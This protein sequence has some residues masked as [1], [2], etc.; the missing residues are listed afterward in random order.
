MARRSVTLSVS[1]GQ[2]FGD[3][4]SAQKVTPRRVGSAHALCVRQLVYNR[5]A[6]GYSSVRK[7]DDYCV[8]SAI[9]I[10]TALTHSVT[11]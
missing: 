4:L 9:H 3:F 2:L 10:V 11:S 1:P 6:I 5:Y 8:P 7:A